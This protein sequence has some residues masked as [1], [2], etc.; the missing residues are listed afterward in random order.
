MRKTLIYIAIIIA[1]IAIIYLIWGL[2]GLS[3]ACLIIAAIAGCGALGIVKSFD[4]S[5]C[6]I[7]CICIVV[8]AIFGFGGFAINSVVKGIE[9]KKASLELYETIKLNPTIKQCKT[10]MYNYPSS[11]NAEYVQQILLNLL[12]E[13][14]QNYDFIAN[15]STDDKVYHI[16]DTPIRILFGF[17]KENQSNA[18]G[19]EAGVALSNICDSLYYIAKGIATIEGWKA[20]QQAVPY[21]H[22][23]DSMYQIEEIENRKWNTE[24]K[25]WSTARCENTISAYKKYKSLYPKGAHYVQAERRLIDL[26]VADVYAGDY[27]SLPA[28]DKTSWGAGPTA[29]VSI[30]N[31]TRYVLTILYSGPD[32]KR[33]VIQA[34]R[35]STVTLKNG[36]YK[37]AASVDAPGVSK[38]AGSENVDGGSYSVEYYIETQYF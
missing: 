25:A 30:T 38:Y 20:Y 5:G 34:G 1:I 29:E 24:S 8:A 10:Y 22:H 19:L 3:T 18:Y 26:E 13:D 31:R 27:G 6:A 15:A 37:V 7:F 23:K 2:E 35:T 28:M 36:T 9:D 21:E 12:V 14:A 4:E 16:P 32:S 17:S 11:D 33:V